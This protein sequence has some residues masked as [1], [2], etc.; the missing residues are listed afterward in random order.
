VTAGAPVIA[1]IL[2][3]PRVQ[4]EPARRQNRIGTRVGIFEG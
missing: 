3:H 1:A 4:D 2:C